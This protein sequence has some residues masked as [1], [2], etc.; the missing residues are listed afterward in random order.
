[1]ERQTIIIIGF[2][3][4]ILGIF[5][6]PLLYENTQYG[7]IFF[8]IIMYFMPALILA[9]ANGFLLR[10]IEQKM[11]DLTLKIGIGFI[12]LL[13]LIL[14]AIGKESPIQ[15]IATF[16]IFGIGI[17]N[18]IWTIKLINEKSVANNV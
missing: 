6:A 4:C 15:F 7:E 12:P 9:I 13:I 18:L 16:G 2:L 14:L 11:R 10:L 5:I 8:L 17:T 1:M 3:F